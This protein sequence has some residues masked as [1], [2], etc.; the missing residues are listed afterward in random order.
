MYA[1]GGVVCTSVRIFDRC[2]SLVGSDFNL[3]TS[4]ILLLDLHG[5]YLDVQCA[6]VHVVHA[7]YVVHVPVCIR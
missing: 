6:N 3:S 1:P 2:L 7:V 4:G 5:E